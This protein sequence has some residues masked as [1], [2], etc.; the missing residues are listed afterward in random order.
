MLGMVPARL[1]VLLSAIARTEFLAEAARGAIGCYEEYNMTCEEH[2]VAYEDLGIS[3][4]ELEDICFRIE[5]SVFKGNF[6][7]IQNKFMHPRFL[8]AVSSKNP[9]CSTIQDVYSHC[10][11]CFEYQF[12][13]GICD[14]ATLPKCTDMPT[15]QEVLE[16]NLSLFKTEE[17]IDAVC[18][19]ERY[20][21]GIVHYSIPLC[22]RAAAVLHLC[23]GFCQHEAASPCFGERNPPTCEPDG[24][25][26]PSN[27]NSTV[28]E[29]CEELREVAFLH[30]GYES[31]FNTSL[32]QDFLAYIPESD[33]KCAEYQDA[34]PHCF[35][36]RGRDAL[37]FDE[38]RQPSC[39]IPEQEPAL[40]VAARVCSMIGRYLPL[41]DL[42]LIQA[43]PNHV[44][45]LFVLA[46]TTACVETRQAY[47]K[48]IWCND[49]ASELPV[50]DWW[51]ICN[52]NVTA[53]A[54]YTERIIRFFDIASPEIGPTTEECEQMYIWWIET[55]A[56]YTVDG[57]FQS[58]AFYNLCEEYICGDSSAEEDIPEPSKE[59]DYLGTNSEAERKALVWSSR[60]SA[61]LSF[62][63]ASF[64]LC[65][66][67][68]N[69]K[70]RNTVYHQILIGMAVFDFVTAIA[71]G[72]AT[73]PID[74]EEGVEGAM[75][76][77]E[78]CVAQ[79]FFIQLGFTSVFYNVSLAFYYVLVISYS[80][81]EFQLQKVRIYLH[82]IPLTIGFGLAFGG[83]TSYGYLE[84]GCHLTPHEDA[85]DPVWQVMV[86][87]VLPLGLSILAITG[88]MVCVYWSVRQQTLK[89]Q[90]WNLGGNQAGR[91]EKAVFWQCVS[92]VLA[93]YITWPLMFSVY[94][95]SIDSND[96]LASFPLAMTVA[97]AAPLQGFS[98][99]VVYLRT[100]LRN[101]ANPNAPSSCST[102]CQKAKALLCKS[103]E[104]NSLH[105]T[106]QLPEEIGASDDAPANDR[107][108]AQA[109]SLHR[110]KI[111]E[112][113]ASQQRG[114]QNA[115]NAV[116]SGEGL[117]GI[118]S[119]YR[120]ERSSQNE[121]DIPN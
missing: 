121:L 41:Y 21:A 75:G 46:N 70:A 38:T 80:W 94:L 106:H 99:S 103:N 28:D 33:P 3:L 63:G 95:F 26:L 43:V 57:I 79:A 31:I 34:Y 39:A 58:I 100:K 76:T 113:V 23:P 51:D 16:S 101:A 54:R 49:A 61:L 108:P 107:D 44:I 8:D 22:E 65:D 17:D 74:A 7:V 62:L 9:F 64:V 66:I 110:D 55:D 109:L 115:A 117:E 89:A 37:C 14:F 118:Q 120:D 114:S 18:E 36:C 32:H 91:M 48:C 85:E 60:A 29:V 4:T 86:F 11:F 116:L 97:F 112:I 56:F 40:G 78:T 69:P 67:L 50:D 82:A 45:D 27:S 59:L 119:E 1:L 77:E 35:W 47:H 68:R 72:F 90:K 98:N 93:F 104:N 53:P 111:A 30:I 24:P 96:G 6:V 10:A 92:Y 5:N 83:I 71:W 13:R 2:K 73:A 84:Y 87:V 15:Q 88:S 105:S 25:F 102:L 81:R 19:A 42:S 52:N 12:E 20:G